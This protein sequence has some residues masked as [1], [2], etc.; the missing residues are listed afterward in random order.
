[1]SFQ[2]IQSYLAGFRAKLS[3][4]GRSSIENKAAGHYRT[5]FRPM[6]QF[7]R[8]QVEDAL[9]ASS[10]TYLDLVSGE[11]VEVSGE[12]VQFRRETSTVSTGFSFDFYSLRGSQAAFFVRGVCK[13]RHI[14]FHLHQISLVL[15]KVRHFLIFSL[16]QFQLSDSIQFIQFISF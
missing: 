9:K 6:Y 8:S 2:V 16:V 5:Q 10:G 1:M 15:R 4:F 7:G 3:S 14:I 12:T 11:T 13:D